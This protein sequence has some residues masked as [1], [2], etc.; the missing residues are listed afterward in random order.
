[1]G[2]TEGGPGDE[3]AQHMEA[4]WEALAFGLGEYIKTAGCF[5][6]IGLGLSGGRDSA[7]GLLVA[8]RWAHSQP[9]PPPYPQV[10]AF[11]MPSPYSSPQTRK[12]AQT[13]AEELG[14]CFAELSI[15]AAYAREK[16]A[17]ESMLGHAANDTTLQNIQAR[18]RS[19]RM[20][21]WANSAQALFLQ[22]GNHSE[23]A[24]GY[25]TLGGDFSGGFALLSDLPKTVVI[26]LLHH[27]QSRL[28]LE[29]LE[30]IL[31][32]PAGPELAQGQK[33]E[34][35]LMP[36]PLLDTLLEGLLG[37]GLLGEGLLAFAQQRLPP[38]DSQALRK[39]INRLQR[40]VFLNQHK[41]RHAPPGLRLYS[42][43]LS[44]FYWPLG[45]PPPGC[46]GE[47]G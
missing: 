15:E 23:K 37:E 20:W 24:V 30:R 6:C 39:H 9:N 44:R 31:A 33:A 27:I 38:M 29:G 3:E 41:W 14:V 4:L 25:T 26:R 35:E 32:L 43:S 18:I 12:A 36:F 40:L 22:T 17:V 45:S 46:L 2:T 13:L 7:L 16:E 10:Y 11:S 42:K 1:M 21:N 28:H 5:K 8:W 47:L 19:L 34:A